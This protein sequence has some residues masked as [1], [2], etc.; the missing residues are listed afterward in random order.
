MTFNSIPY[1]GHFP[2]FDLNHGT[3]RVGLT[4]A[5]CV[6]DVVWWYNLQRSSYSHGFGTTHQ[7]GPVPLLSC[8]LALTGGL[9]GIPC[10]GD[11]RARTW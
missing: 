3:V 2:H 5:K 4:L 11:P 9:S 10:V 1:T 6:G 7:H 8:L